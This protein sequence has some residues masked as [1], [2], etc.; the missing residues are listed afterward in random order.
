MNLKNF[1][2]N[3]VLATAL[4]GAAAFQAH[5]VA[6][7]HVYDLGAVTPTSPGII[8]GVLSHGDFFDIIK[9]TLPTNIASTYSVLDFPAPPFLKTVFASGTLWSNP[10]GVYGNFDDAIVSSLIPNVG[11][12]KLSLSLSPGGAGV[13]GPYYLKIF[14]TASGTGAGPLNGIYSGAITV[15]AAPIP[16]PESYAMFLAGLGVMGAIALRRKK[17]R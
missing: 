16:E 13:A 2:V 11:F 17:A 1:A 12:S 5:A 4:L 7:D 8:Q 9:F 3:G 14:G 10:D 6:P 15:T